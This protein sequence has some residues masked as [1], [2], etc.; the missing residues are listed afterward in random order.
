MTV[1]LSSGPNSMFNWV[2]TSTNLMVPSFLLLFS[3][4]RLS[5]SKS[6]IHDR[7]QSSHTYT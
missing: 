7:L 3:D 4:T 2:V 1:G 5:P 6:V